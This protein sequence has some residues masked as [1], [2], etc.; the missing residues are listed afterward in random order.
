[1]YR[2]LKTP[3]I[4]K[5]SQVK[6][7]V[8]ILVFLFVSIFSLL[9]VMYYFS[10]PVFLETSKKITIPEGYSLIQTAQ[11]LE[12]ESLIRS[13]LV[14]RGLGQWQDVSVKAGT[15]LF[16]GQMS[17]QQILY[18]LDQSDYGDI[19]LSVT[20]PEGST[21]SQVGDIFY[22]QGFENFDRTKFDTLAKGKEGYLFPDTYNFLPSVH[23]E[24]VVEKLLGTFD[25]KTESLIASLPVNRTWE[26]IIIMASLIEKEATGDI[27]EK[28][29]V[30]G[31][32]WKRLDEGK[33][34]QVDAPFQYIH[35]NVNAKD[36]RVDGPYNT[37]TR[38]G[39]TPTP[40]GNPG[41]ASIQ[42]ALDPLPSSYYFYLHAR[43]GNI[44][45]GR[46]Y[47]EHINNINRYLR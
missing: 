2:E 39:L 20:I 17:I 32:L 8:F 43:D 6:R 9:G 3:I 16:E 13:A 33:L 44:Y 15:Y 26:D 47:N 5:K 30:S 34:L 41:I 45:Y 18:R 22:N 27:N 23:T 40:I 46:T 10:Q 7:L 21:V 25:K 37:Y 24:T 14:F 1:M 12:D 36:L 42:A 31:I 11:L 4:S 19:F 28:R 38:T 29:T 35:G